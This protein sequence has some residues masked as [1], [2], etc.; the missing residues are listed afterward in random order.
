MT[1]VR[2]NSVF[3]GS[4]GM[5]EVNVTEIHIPNTV[6]SIDSG[7]FDNQTKTSKLKYVYIEAG[8][9]ISEI[10]SGT[11]SACNNLVYIQFENLTEVTKIDGVSNCNFTGKLDLSKCT[12]LTT[13]GN[14]AFYNCDNLTEITL[15]DSLETIGNDVF[16]NCKNAYLASPY[17]PTNLKTIGK[18]FFYNAK[19]FNNLLIFPV[20]FQ[21]IGDEAFQ[22]MVVKGGA[23]GNEFNLVF[24]G[25]M[26]SVVYLNGNGHQKH[27][28]K[29]TVYFAQNTRDEY[30]SNGFYIKPSS[31]STTSIPGAIRAVFCKG[32]GAGTNGNV[33]GV[34]YIYI[35]S[36]SGASYTED[37]VNDATNGFD[38]ENHRHFGAQNVTPA[39]CG[40]NGAR[41][42]DCIVCDQMI[43]EV[44]PATGDHKYT[45]DHDCTTAEVCDTCHQTVIEALEH[46]I[47]TAYTYANGYSNKGLKIVGCTREG[48]EHGERTVLDAL[49][50]S[51][52]YSK[53]EN[54]VG[55]THS[56][57]VSKKAIDDYRAYLNE[58]EE[59]TILYGI[60][61]AI[62][63]GNGTPVTS[64]GTIA[65][66]YKAVMTEN[67]QTAYTILTVKL[68]G[69][70][71]T[72]QK[73]N[74]GAY[75]I[76]NG[77]VNYIYGL[78]KQTGKKAE[79]VSYSDL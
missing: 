47:G 26:S 8:N 70:E 23:Q 12:K 7:A 50:T 63:D 37:M 53:E 21:S 39:T 6:S 78:T 54:G 31:Q 42:V 1:E 3:G 66:G 64:D 43:G 29:V 22:D 60:I 9:N 57:K 5:Y 48:C 79:S 69:I 36:N 2:A 28:E 10:K 32:T 67:S 76:I 19:S 68:G 30:N 14:S 13:L 51:L 49:I 72:T 75:I 40:V 4:K 71:D 65:E 55:I 62:D 61:A 27:A 17:L 59:T 44:I 18:Q 38:F 41:G 11:F 15:P 58:T 74:L 34:E 33:T 45:D 46:I 25:K 20:G 56:V 24:L 16:W 35:T 77:D 52:G 73:L